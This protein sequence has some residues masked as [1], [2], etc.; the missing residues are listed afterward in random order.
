MVFM[1]RGPRRK[2][3]RRTMV[4][5]GYQSLA[6]RKERFS[7]VREKKTPQ[8][9]TVCGTGGG[10]RTGKGGKR[11]ER[12]GEGG[13]GKNGETLFFSRGKKKPSKKGGHCSHGFL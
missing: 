12:L 11:A 3:V 4:G 7:G 6:E 1:L 8:I 5:K 2:K 9:W 10:S 13:G